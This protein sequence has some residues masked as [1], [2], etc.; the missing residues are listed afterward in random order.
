MNKDTVASQW[1]SSVYTKGAPKGL[2]KTALVGKM[3][4]RL[5]P[6]LVLLL[7]FEQGFC[8]LCD[9]FHGISDGNWIQPRGRCATG[10]FI[11]ASNTYK[12]TNTHTQTKECKSSM[13]KDKIAGQCI[14]SCAK[15][16][17]WTKCVLI[18]LTGVVRKEQNKEAIRHCVSD[19]SVFIRFLIHEHISMHKWDKR[20]QVLVYSRICLS[21][22]LR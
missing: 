22:T 9:C 15:L 16:D 18:L 1:F 20:L 6:V 13:K 3:V 5:L 19:K 4:S 21:P 10:Y 17:L 7:A 11:P 12:H 2:L 8:Y 14:T